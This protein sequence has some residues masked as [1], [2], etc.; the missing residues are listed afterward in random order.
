MMEQRYD[1]QNQGNNK[2]SAGFM[3]QTI[4]A[5]FIAILVPRG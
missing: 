2:A 1:I 4:S 5:V 3:D